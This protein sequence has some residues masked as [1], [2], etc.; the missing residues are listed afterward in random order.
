[1]FYPYESLM[2]MLNVWVLFSLSLSA[3]G[4]TG[5][6]QEREVLLLYHQHV[7]FCPESNHN[8]ELTDLEKLL[9]TLTS[10]I[11]LQLISFSSSLTHYTGPLNQIQ[12]V[13]GNY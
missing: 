4:E 8:G 1:M 7:L 3:F 2:C 12:V 13:A 6:G 5:G 11:S 9:V 10:P